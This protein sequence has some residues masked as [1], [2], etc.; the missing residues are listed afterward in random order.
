VDAIDQAER[1]AGREIFVSE[2]ALPPPADDLFT[3][4]ELRGSTVVTVGV[5]A[6]PIAGVRHSIPAAAQGLCRQVARLQP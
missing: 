1:L 3:A 5:G 2:E 6:T 4:D